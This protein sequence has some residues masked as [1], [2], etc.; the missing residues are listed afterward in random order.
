[1]H[2]VGLLRVLTLGKDELMPQRACHLIGASFATLR[3]VVEL[4]SGTPTK[5]S[6][7]TAISLLF[8]TIPNHLSPVNHSR[9]IP[10][11]I[12]GRP[13]PEAAR[14]LITATA[15]SRFLELAGRC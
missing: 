15:S 2:P 7:T 12:R 10:C 14:E 13:F 4:A 5:A 1:M 8:F 3:A 11:E 6:Q 9:A